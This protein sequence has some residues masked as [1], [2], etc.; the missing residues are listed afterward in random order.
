[1]KTDL[2]PLCLPPSW[3]YFQDEFPISLSTLH[4]SFNHP[5]YI[6]STFI[7]HSF[8]INSTFYIL[9]SLNPSLP[10]SLEGGH[11][12][13]RVGRVLWK[14]ILRLAK[15]NTGRIRKALRRTSV[16]M[17]VNECLHVA[18]PINL[19]LVLVFRW[20]PA[21]SRPLQGRHDAGWGSKIRS[22]SP[23]FFR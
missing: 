10:C 4:P 16:S 5:F 17:A 11:R 8:Y 15:E 19:S 12:W 9:H 22:S 13:A 6:H 7:L 1:M 20:A 2:S 23:S 3:V 21:L 18:W 14:G